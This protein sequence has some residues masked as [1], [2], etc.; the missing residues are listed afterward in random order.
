M[1]MENSLRVLQLQILMLLRRVKKMFTL[2]QV[3]SQISLSYESIE[4]QFFLFIEQ[5]SKIVKLDF[6]LNQNSI[7][8][9]D[10]T[11]QGIHF[12]VSNNNIYIASW[13]GKSVFIYHTNDEITFNKIYTLSTLDFALASVTI[14]NDKI[15]A[16]TINRRILVYN[17]TS[18]ALIQNMTNV[19]SNIIRSIKFDCNG[20]MIYSCENHPMVRIMGANGINSTFLLNDTFTRVDEAFVDSKSRLWIG[21]TNGSV[22]YN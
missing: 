11:I 19:C 2:G 14:N 6:D 4:N 9:T 15:Y 1:K 7:V 10:N 20:N 8:I 22:V 3:L 12:D 21:G 16:G 17:K 13:N 18:Y 5:G